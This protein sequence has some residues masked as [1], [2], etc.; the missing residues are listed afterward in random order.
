MKRD[1]LIFQTRELLKHHFFG[2]LSTF[3]KHYPFG[4]LVRYSLDNHGQPVFLLSQIAEHTKNLAL[5]NKANLFILEKDK[6][7]IQ[8]CSRLSLSGSVVEIHKDDEDYN[9]CL[10]AHFAYFPESQS[11]LEQLDFKPYRLVV[12]ECHYVGGFAAAHKIAGKEYRQPNPLDDNSLNRIISH[13][14]SDHSDALVHYCK[15]SGFQ[16]DGNTPVLVAVDAKGFQIRID[17]QIKRINFPQS[18]HDAGTARDAFVAMAR[19]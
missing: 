10:K 5:N 9:T 4:S 17:Q 7:N 13:M 1:T 14:N 15:T 19:S 2:T 16:L 12:E 3:G 6:E 11:Y 18:I 8:E